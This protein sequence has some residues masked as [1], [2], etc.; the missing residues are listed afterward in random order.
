MFNQIMQRLPRI[1]GRVIRDCDTY[2]RVRFRPI[3]G[4]HAGDPVLNKVAARIRH[5]MTPYDHYLSQGMTK[6]QAREL[7]QPT[8]THY[9]NLWRG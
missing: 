4:T 5:T 1:P 7:V 3:G 9:L 6:A 2:Y 8:I